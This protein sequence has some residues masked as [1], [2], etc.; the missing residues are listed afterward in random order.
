ML[1]C[2]EGF[3]LT[4]IAL[5]RIA[6]G[7]AVASDKRNLLSPNF[8]VGS[9]LVACASTHGELLVAKREAKTRKSEHFQA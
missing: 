5:E 7:R 1:I 8:L 3:S 4:E 2:G 6:V 9:G